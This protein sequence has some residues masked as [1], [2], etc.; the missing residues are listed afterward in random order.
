MKPDV[1]MFAINDKIAEYSTVV[2]K[3]RGVCV[4]TFSRI[5]WYL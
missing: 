3:T 4:G 5:N 2:P 1:G